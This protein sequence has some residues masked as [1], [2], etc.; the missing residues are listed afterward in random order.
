MCAG[1][2]YSLHFTDRHIV[3]IN[4]SWLLTNHIFIYFGFIDLSD[5][6]GRNYVNYSVDLLS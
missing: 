5:F 1:D 4:L 3:A 2:H 6:S